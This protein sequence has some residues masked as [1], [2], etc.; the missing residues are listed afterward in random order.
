MATS[1]P[2]ERMFTSA[3]SSAGLTKV[4][5]VAIDVE[6]ELLGHRGPLC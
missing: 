4:V 6:S 2:N 5:N 1:A 3:V